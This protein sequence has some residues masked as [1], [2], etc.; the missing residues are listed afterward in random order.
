MRIALI[1]LIA[2]ICAGCTHRPIDN[3]YLTFRFDMSYDD[4]REIVENSGSDIYSDT[5]Q[6]PDRA[7]IEKEKD[8]DDIQVLAAL[9][10]TKSSDP[11]AYLL[12]AH[13]KL[14]LMRL[15]YAF[16]PHEASPGRS[17]NA[18][19]A[20]F[21]RVVVSQMTAA[22]GPAK[23]STSKSEGKDRYETVVWA[24]DKVEAVARM[25]IDGRS[26]QPDTTEPRCGSL[27]AIVKFGSPSERKRFD[28][29]IER[30]A[31]G[32]TSTAP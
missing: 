2:L 18:C 22:F 4:V 19:N 3:P 12:F 29:A 14:K 21:R 28:D 7:K 5:E 10:R 15:E 31:K 6:S 16:L 20:L 11:S 30:T 13:E 32:H 27:D 24:L 25:F 17:E 1:T 23:S 26:S 9:L 8:P